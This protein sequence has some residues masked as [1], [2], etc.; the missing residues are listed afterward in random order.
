MIDALRQWA[1]ALVI[2]AMAG[3]IATAASNSPNMKK[4]IKFTCALVALAVMIAPISSL[5]RGLP[6][7]FNTGNIGNN[8]ANN[9]AAMETAA[10]IPGLGY[11][12]QRLIIDKSAEMLERRISDIIEQ[13]TGIKPANIYIYVIYGDNLNNLNYHE[14]LEN[15]EIGI[16][17]IIVSMPEGAEADIDISGIEAYL[18]EILDCEVVIE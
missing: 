7:I 5:F 16:E 8:N 6:G 2:T 10:D 18:R 11:E 4:Y 13:K 3:G 1:F 12:L 15:L 9:N 17:K 14:N